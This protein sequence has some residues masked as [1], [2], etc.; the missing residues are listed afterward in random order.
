[1]KICLISNSF[2]LVKTGIGTYPYELIKNLPCNNNEYLLIHGQKNKEI[3]KI[4]NKKI[5]FEDIIITY[6]P[7]FL[8][9]VIQKMLL[10]PQYLIKNNPDIIHDTYHFAPFIF[11]KKFKKIITVYDISPILYPKTHKYSRVIMHKYFFPIILKSSDKIISISENTKRD[12]MDHFKIPEDK[13][14]VIPLASNKNFKKLDENDILKIKSKYNFEYPFIL[15]VGTLEPRKNIPNLLK[16]FYS[17]KKQEITHKLVIAGGKGWK[18]QEIFK[19]IKKLNLQNDVIFTGYVPDE[20]LPG[21]YNAADLFVYPSLYEGFGLPPLE[22][23]QCG[24]PVITSNTSS[25][26]E[27]VGDAGIMINPYDVDELAN[28]MYEVLTNEDLGNELSKQGIER[29]K[30]FSWKKCAEEHLKVY[31]EVYNM[32]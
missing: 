27:V 13:I 5:G 3:T 1:M 20:D 2:D 17:I 32:K 26:P 23:M 19:T 11:L 16:A 14:K 8:G 4:I 18:Y 24:T 9:K 29:A 31:K 25:L 28:K 10:I 12:I 22:A 6:P 15:Y 30:L 7:I 21:L